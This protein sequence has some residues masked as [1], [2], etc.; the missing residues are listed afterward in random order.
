M[1]EET[2]AL[3]R[4]ESLQVAL[5]LDRILLLR[6][7]QPLR[8]PAHV[9]VD[10]DSLRIA[11]FGGDDVR[12]LARHPGEA[13]ELLEAVRDPTAEL[14]EQHHHRRAQGPRLLTE[15]AGSEDVPLELL[16]RDGQV[17][18]R[19]LV[20][21]EQPLRDAVHVHVRRLRREHHRDEQLELVPK[22]ER[23]RRLRVLGGEPLDDR[24]DPRP[25]GT[26][27]E[28]RLVDVAPRHGWGS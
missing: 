8:E 24:H 21:L 6:Q 10:D 22:A 9:R 12:R 19:T 25:L 18:L 17:V 14:L 20:L 4:H 26:D 16:L 5:D 3:A 28:P 1:R 11:E 23:D 7:P 15:E 13:H 2:P 27:A